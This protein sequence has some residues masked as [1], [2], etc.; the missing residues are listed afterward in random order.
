[1][2]TKED[3]MAKAREVWKRGTTQEDPTGWTKD[4]ILNEIL[5]RDPDNKARKSWNRE[6][7]LIALDDVKDAGISLKL[8]KELDPDTK[9]EISWGK[10]K[11]RNSLRAART[12]KKAERIQSI[13]EGAVG[14]PPPDP[15]TNPTKEERTL[16]RALW[17][18]ANYFPR[19]IETTST[20]RG[21]KER[22]GWLEILLR[23]H[24][25]GESGL[26]HEEILSLCEEFIFYVAHT[27][28]C[29][30]PSLD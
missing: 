13:A 23:K 4:V 11:I 8:L 7:L 30:P 14:S 25:Q 20:L 26:T 18:I 19:T 29:N 17:S 16:E 21:F 28:S 12:K 2:T 1:M 10:D 3:P 24:R 22:A 27:Y 9:A 15:F 5:R 6:R